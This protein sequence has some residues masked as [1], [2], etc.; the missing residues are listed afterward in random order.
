MSNKRDYY[1]VLGV[2]R[3][4][5]LNEIKTAFRK[6]AM[7]YHPDRNKEPGAEEKFKEIN[8][9]YQVLSNEEKRAIYDQYGFEGLNQN[10]FSS[11]NINP[12]DIFNQFFNQSGNG[13]GFSFNFSSSNDD[14]FDIFDN[15]F[16]TGNR[17]RRRRHDAKYE[18]DIKAQI[19]ISF[20]E[21]VL[22]IEKSISIKTK[23]T[24][25]QC[26]G[27]GASNNGKDIATC[28]EC[29]GSGYVIRQTR[30]FLGIMQSKT[31]CQ[32]CGGTGKII[33]S[34]CQKCKGKG[35]TEQ[36]QDITFNIPPGI[37][38]G[39]I[40]KLLDKGNEFHGEKGSIFITILVRPSK[41][42][43]KIKDTINVKVK[44]DP[45]KAICGG[46]I[47]VPT[48]Y[49]VKTINLNPNTASGEKI[50]ISGFGIKNLKKK[51]FGNKNG[52][53]VAEII[54]SKPNNYSKN[55]LQN[56]KTLADLENADV[57]NYIEGAKKE[58]SGGK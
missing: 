31:I 53:L 7:K 20:I 34:K 56:L 3:T 46:A 8:E 35:Y 21:S 58:I 10:G 48:P 16:N 26:N 25:E 50:I 17:S 5:T 41:Y 19:T 18:L 32:K 44:V 38:N 57:T 2:G 40:I 27:N 22:G 39:S 54:Y 47:N 45:I 4:A 55:Q 52:D 14:D 30:T 33:K 9:A 36:I 11:E 13:G 12:F 23:K 51:P 42:F 29:N 24:C 6:L 49:G 37:E 43:Y 15:I 28:D 1:E